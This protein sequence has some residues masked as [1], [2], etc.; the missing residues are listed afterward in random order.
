MG[1]H[2]VA[3]MPAPEPKATCP[4]C[5]RPVAMMKSGTCVYCG[6]RISDAEVEAPKAGLPPELMFELQPRAAKISTGTR[7]IRRVIALGLS[8]LLVAVFMGPCMK[9]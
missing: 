2:A 7:W 8:S 9:S 6:H 4:S 5:H 3:R 1:I